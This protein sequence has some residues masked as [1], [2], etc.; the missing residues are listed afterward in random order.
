MLVLDNYY[1]VR[2]GYKTLC[3]PFKL[4]KKIWDWWDLRGN[5]ENMGISF[6][7]AWMFEDVWDVVVHGKVGLMFTFD[8]NSYSKSRYVG[9]TTQIKTEIMKTFIVEYL[10]GEEVDN[11]G[12]IRYFLEGYDIKEFWKAWNY[13]VKGINYMDYTVYIKDELTFIELR[14][15]YFLKLGL[16]DSWEYSGV[17]DRVRNVIKFTSWSKSGN[18]KE[19]NKIVNLC[20]GKIL[21]DGVWMCCFE[22][23]K[24]EFETFCRLIS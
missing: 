9:I 16:D 15:E 21:V 13:L 6:V 19:E 18:I 1:E 10:G 4:V 12:V 11:S 14:N 17:Y 3:S 22:G 5:D 20:N 8:K 24:E 7:N 23:T 2:D